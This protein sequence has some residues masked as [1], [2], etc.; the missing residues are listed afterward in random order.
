MLI[1]NCSLL[2]KWSIRGTIFPINVKNYASVN[3]FKN[4]INI[5]FRKIQYTKNFDIYKNNIEAKPVFK[6][7][8]NFPDVQVVL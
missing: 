1:T 4:K 8:F 7:I 6:K 2:R 5:I 3:V